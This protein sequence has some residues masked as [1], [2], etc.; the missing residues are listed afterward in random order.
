MKALSLASGLLTVALAICLCW[1]GSHLLPSLKFGGRRTSQPLAMSLSPPRRP[2]LSAEELRKFQPNEAG[3]VPILEYH[4]IRPHEGYMGRSRTNFG[5][6]LSRLYAEGYR[7][8]ALADYLSNRIDLPAGTS[9]VVIT[10]D[11]ARRSQFRYRADGT[12]DPDCAVGLLKSFHE[13]HSDFPLKATFFVL[14]TCP[15]EEQKS[16]ARKMKDLVDWGFEI[17]NHTLN[18]RN[19]SRLSDT[20]AEKEIGGGAALLQQMAP[21]ARIETIAF[22]EGC[23]PRNSQLISE[24]VYNGFHYVNRA[25]FLAASTPALSPI[26]KKQDRL[27]VPRIVACEAT[28][29]ATYWLNRIKSGHVKRYVSDGDPETTTVPRK[30]AGQV[31]P[32]R[33]NGAALKFY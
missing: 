9:P 16:A 29:G 23:P 18:H 7:P 10:F 6:D 14:P 28:Y 4:D 5:R 20:Q 32:A 8:I 1:P 31:D 3:V 12:L 19:L 30:F 2:P 24:G 25:G 21:G 15:F 33:L 13:A 17:G 27:H 26:A 22:P 11:D